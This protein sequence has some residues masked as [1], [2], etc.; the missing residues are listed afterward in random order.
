M[1]AARSLRPATRLAVATVAV[2]ALALG[3]A[4][5]GGNEDVDRADFQE[6][7][8]ERTTIPE[9]VATCITDRVYEQFDQGEI[10]DIVVAA[11]VEELQG[12]EGELEAINQECQAA[13]Q[14]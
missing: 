3:T 8:I 10:N 13:N 5:C 4:G 6:K 14:G 9:D 2:V 12:A 11:T 7:L 1:P